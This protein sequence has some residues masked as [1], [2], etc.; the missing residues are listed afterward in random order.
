MLVAKVGRRGQMALP[1]VIRDGFNIR[2]GDKVAFIR[3]GDEYVLQP[4]SKTLLD[5]RGSVQVSG[6]QDFEAIRKEARA[7]RTQKRENDV[8]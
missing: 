8:S 7:S 3:R 1:S 6:V 2:E 5:I 4:L